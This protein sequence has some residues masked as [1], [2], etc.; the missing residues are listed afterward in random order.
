MNVYQPRSLHVAET[1][2]A[3]AQA[4]HDHGHH[5]AYAGAANVP[6]PQWTQHKRLESVKPLT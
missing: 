2:C 6:S 1:V 3:H 5:D 4:V